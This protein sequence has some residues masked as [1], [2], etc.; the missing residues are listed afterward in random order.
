MVFK[1]DLK[2]AALYTNLLLVIISHLSGPIISKIVICI[3]RRDNYQF[4]W[5]FY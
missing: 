5:L 2:N 1:E 3:N 4:V